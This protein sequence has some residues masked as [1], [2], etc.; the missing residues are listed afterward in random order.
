MGGYG[1]AAR[2]GNKAKAAFVNDSKNAFTMFT[3]FTNRAESFISL[4]ALVNAREQKCS[5]TF[6]SVHEL[7]WLWAAPA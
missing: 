5:R 3:M 6:T 2:A 1:E 4:C 7:R